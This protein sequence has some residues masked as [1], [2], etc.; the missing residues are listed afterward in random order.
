MSEKDGGPA[1]P[2]KRDPVARQIGG[3][4]LMADGFVWTKYEDRD[5]L[6]MSLRDYFAAQALAAFR[7]EHKDEQY[8]GDSGNSLLIAQKCY[9]MADA[10]LRERIK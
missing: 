7:R 6:G 4:T 9:V 10:M 8:H 5:V 3:S 2:L 1:F